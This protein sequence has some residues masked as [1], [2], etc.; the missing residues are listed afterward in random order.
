MESRARSVT[1]LEG[2]RSERSLPRQDAGVEANSRL[3]AMTGALLLVLL[4]AEG[5]TIVRIGPLL[6]VHVFL[7]ALLVPP[8]AVK[9]A[10]AIYRFGRYYSGSPAYERKGPPP[11]ILRLLGPVLVALTVVLFATGIALLFVGVNQ[12]GTLLFLHRASFV[13]WFGAMAIHV[14]GHLIEVGKIAPRDFR[15]ATRQRG[16]GGALRQLVIL[17][18]VAVGGVLGTALLGRAGHYF[19]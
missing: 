9:M 13:L 6:K 11:I 5:L 4:A 10:S 12:R 1:T 2:A 17:G 8:V 3:T 18:S 14:L 19:F 15:R 16:F 7:G